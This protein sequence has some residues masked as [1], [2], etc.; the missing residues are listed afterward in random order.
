LSAAKAVTAPVAKTFPAMSYKQRGEK[1][2]QLVVF[3]APVKEI[4]RFA[5]VDALSPSARGPQ[6]EQK[7]ARVD[8]I[9]R[10]LSADA[11]N[12][13]PTA[14][15]L[16]FAKGMASFRPGISAQMGRRTVGARRPLNRKSIRP[17]RALSLS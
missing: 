12:T 4:L 14:V 8:A 11:Q 7:E 6:R 15:I 16:A 1:G 10:F 17:I 9:S 13:I 3:V 5:T 2:P